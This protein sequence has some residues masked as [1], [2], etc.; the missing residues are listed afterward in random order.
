[1]FCCPLFLFSPF[2]SL[3]LSP[4]FPFT[5]SSQNLYCNSMRCSFDMT[6]SVSPVLST[7]SCYS[8][9]S[10]GTTSNMKLEYPEVM[11]GMPSNIYSSSQR[12]TMPSNGIYPA[13]QQR[14][15]PSNIMKQVSAHSSIFCDITYWSYRPFFLTSSSLPLTESIIVYLILL[16]FSTPT[17][18]LLFIY[19]YCIYLYCF[20]Y[21][22]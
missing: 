7:E 10:S 5:V 22:N 6:C 16:F 9:Y 8:S 1:M 15:I 13:L 14:I 12:E 2:S 4:L 3:P 17:A 18:Y 11:C 19:L 20:K 21:F